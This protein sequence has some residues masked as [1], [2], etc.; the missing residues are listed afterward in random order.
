MRF[1]RLWAIL[2]LILWTGVG[3]IGCGSS[4]KTE[5]KSSQTLGKELM[6][7]DDAF[8]KGVITEKEYQKARK[9]LL[10]GKS[11]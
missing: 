4:T 8:K 10:S 7:L 3:F 1:L 2:V 11:R 6:D 9:D 5:V